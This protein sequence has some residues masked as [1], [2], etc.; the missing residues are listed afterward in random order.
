MEEQ[1]QK[2]QKFVQDNYYADLLKKV[3]KGDKFL[4]VDFARL[5][6]FDPALAESLLEQLVPILVEEQAPDDIMSFLG[7]I[8]E[9]S[10]NTMVKRIVSKDLEGV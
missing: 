3:R 8:D 1:V 5:S 2:F 9:A 10:L 7:I 4:V 6:Q